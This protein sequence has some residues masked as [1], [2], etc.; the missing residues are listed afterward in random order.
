MHP[1]LP[2]R[3]SAL[4]RWAV[5]TGNGTP[6]WTRRRRARRLAEWPSTARIRSWKAERSGPFAALVHSLSGVGG[7][8]QA[9]E[10]APQALA[11]PAL[12]AYE[13]H[14]WRGLRYDGRAVVHETGRGD[15]GPDTRLD[16]SRHPD[17]ALAIG[18]E[19]LHPIARA[20]LSRRLC[21]QSIHVD[22]AALAQPGRQRAGLDEAHRAQPSIDPRLIGSAGISHASRMA[23]REKASPV[24]A[25]STFPQ[26]LADALHPPRRGWSGPAGRHRMRRSDLDNVLR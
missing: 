18:D 1:S 9:L 4:R 22:V 2:L 10:L 16:R 26:R 13:H 19:R 15:G 25:A 5:R 6:R 21:R 14:R 11:R 17:D 20:N 12:P 24:R 8:A 7:P 3:A 23:R